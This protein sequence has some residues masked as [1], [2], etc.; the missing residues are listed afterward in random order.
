[1]EATSTLRSK[2][3]K[4]WTEL[5]EGFAYPIPPS[6]GPIFAARGQ[7]ILGV[8]TAAFDCQIEWLIVKGIADYAGG[9]QLASES[10]YS[11]AS[12]MAASLVA[13]ILSEPCVFHS[14]PHYQGQ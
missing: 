3:T 10:W 8:F 5:P 9:S 4:W 11:C 1:M 12:V 13:H 6:L 7:V 14:W 2:K